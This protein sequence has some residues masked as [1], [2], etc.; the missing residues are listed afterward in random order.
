MIF[1]RIYLALGLLFALVACAEPPRLS[2]SERAY[3]VVRGV[4]FKAPAIFGY[5]DGLVGKPVNAQEVETTFRAAIA[6]HLSAPNGTVPVNVQVTFSDFRITTGSAMIFGGETAGSAS[7]IVQIFGANGT[8]L[9]ST[10]V[11]VDTTGISG[12]LSDGAF[13][14]PDSEKI[15]ILAEKFARQASAGIVA[16]Y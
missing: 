12:E 9:A 7:G 5:G 1:R 4:G 6:R 3:I 14:T 15:A 2:P 11:S 16:Y 10:F 13:R 8:Q